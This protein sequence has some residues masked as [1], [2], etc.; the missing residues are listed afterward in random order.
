[1]GDYAFERKKRLNDLGI[2]PDK[3]PA[4]MK[5]VSVTEK[6]VNYNVEIEL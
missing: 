1:M 2:K 3:G 4:P 6:G 5:K